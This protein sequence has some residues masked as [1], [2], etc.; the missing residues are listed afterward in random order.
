M[1]QICSTPSTPAL[2]EAMRLLGHH[3][4]QIG[5]EVLAELEHIVALAL[6]GLHG[7][8]RLL[9]ILDGDEA[10]PG[11]RAFGLQLADPRAERLPGRPDPGPANLAQIGAVLLGERPRAVLVGLDLDASG[12][13]EME[14]E[15]TPK[16]FPVAMT[17]D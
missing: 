13:A 15:L 6:L 2:A 10:A 1:L 11:A 4:H 5:A 17:I 12:D 8:A 7:R 16:S 14:I 9:G 3:L